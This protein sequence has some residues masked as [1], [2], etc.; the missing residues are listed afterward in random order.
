MSFLKWIQDQKNNFQG[1]IKFD[2]ILAK[3]TYYKIGGPA[4]VY[5]SPQSLEDLVCIKHGLALCP[6]PYFILGAG[7][8][9]LVSDLG[10]RGLIIRTNMLNRKIEEHK[11]RARK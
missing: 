4:D 7:S 8:N 10:F 11:E 3:Y 2:E 1:E 6:V 5:V 9:L